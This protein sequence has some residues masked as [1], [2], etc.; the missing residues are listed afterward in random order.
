MEVDVN[1][2]PFTI[3]NKDDEDAWNQIVLANVAAHAAILKVSID[4]G[5]TVV[6]FDYT[7][8]HP[9]SKNWLLN[10]QIEH[11]TINDQLTGS[12]NMPDLTIADFTT[13]SGF[14]SWHD[15]HRA[16]HEFQNTL[17]NL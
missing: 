7:N 9:Q 10:H 13:Q 3:M 8:I 14:E 5:F 15:L 1:L 11:Q 6:H 17:L 12:G 4:K 2:T 16:L